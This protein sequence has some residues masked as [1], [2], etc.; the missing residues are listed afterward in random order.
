MLAVGMMTRAY[1]VGE[2]SHIAVFE[3]S[4]LIFASFWAWVLFG[5]ALDLAGMVGIAMIIVS[6]A[7]IALRS[8]QA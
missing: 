7:V 5:N 8:S 6:G 2:T 1:Q 3:Y 4:F